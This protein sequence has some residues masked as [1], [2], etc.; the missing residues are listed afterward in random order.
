MTNEL[1]KMPYDKV[2]IVNVNEEQL[3][4]HVGVT[5]KKIPNWEKIEILGGSQ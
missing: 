1:E 4:K 2:F 5:S 3:A